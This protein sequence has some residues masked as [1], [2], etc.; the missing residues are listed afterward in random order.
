VAQAPTATLHWPP[1]GGHG[2][3]SSWFAVGGC[4]KRRCQIRA[5]KFARSGQVTIPSKL[6]HGPWYC[7]WF[8]HMSCHPPRSG[9]CLE[10]TACGSRTITKKPGGKAVVKPKD[11]I[12]VQR[13]QKQIQGHY[14]SYTSL[15]RQVY[16]WKIPVAG[17]STGKQKRAMMFCEERGMKWFAPR[18]QADANKH[19]HDYFAVAGKYSTLCT[20]AYDEVTTQKWMEDQSNQHTAY[21]ASHMS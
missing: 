10:G 6:S 1:R 20:V 2:G 14:K 7:S 21:C 5:A 9:G 19:Q 8:H 12:R 3:R 4:W 18:S 11:L 17:C 16:V 13:V 15:G